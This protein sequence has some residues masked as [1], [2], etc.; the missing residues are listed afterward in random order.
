MS[1]F[2]MAASSIVLS[3]LAQ[4]VLKAG[5]SGVSVRAALA[6]PFS[7]DTVVSVL[8]DR[9][10]VGGFL[11]YGLGALVW[12]GVLSR[13]DVSKA[14]PLVGLGFAMTVAVGWLAGESFALARV[15]GVLLICSGVWVVA[16]T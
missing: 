3:V 8:T 4:F 7:I 15:V 10:I 11:L 1:T 5:M 14:Y 13:W 6:K 2:L 16:R 9:F 12:L